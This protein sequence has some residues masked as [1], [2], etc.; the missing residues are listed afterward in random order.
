MIWNIV[1]L[2]AGIAATIWAVRVR[3]SG[4]PVWKMMA[5]AALGAFGLASYG[6]VAPRVW[7]GIMLSALL[8]NTYALSSF[9]QYRK[10]ER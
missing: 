7:V 5:G 1:C 6:L 10:R 3:R 8:L 2:L 4:D 9:D